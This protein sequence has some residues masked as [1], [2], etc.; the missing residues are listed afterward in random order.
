VKASQKVRGFAFPLANIIASTL[1]G[2]GWT[3][4][5]AH[6][7]IC[8]PMAVVTI[9]CGAVGFIMTIVTAIKVVEDGWESVAGKCRRCERLED[10]NRTLLEA[11]K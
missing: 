8:V 10:Q 4:W 2:M 1:G 11:I 5:A 6:P 9:G 3:Y 7:V